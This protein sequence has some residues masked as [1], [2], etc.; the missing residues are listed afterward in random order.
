[1]ALIPTLRKRP[2]HLGR[3][4]MEKIRRVDRPTTRITADVPR[5]PQRANFFNRARFGDLGAKPA[6]EVSRFVAK[7]PLSAALSRL[8]AAQRLFHEG[9]VAPGQAPLPEDPQEVA[10]HIKALCYFLDADIVGICEVPAYAWYSHDLQGNP[11][12]ARHRYAIVML[13]DQGYETMAGSSGDDW[14]SGAQS[15]RAY[16]KGSMIACTVADYLRQLGF[17]ARAHTDADSQVLHL[18]LTLLAGLGELG[19]IGELVLNPFLG[20]RFKTSVVTTNLTLTVDK[21]IDFGLQDFCSSCMKCARECP[22]A[23]ISFGD[24][25]MFNGYEMW[26][27]DVEACVRY[28]VMNPG[29]SACGRCM[30]VCPF[31]K[32]GLFQYR[33]ALWVAIRIPPLRR[34][35]IWLDDALG[36]GECRP[37]W[38]WWLDLEKQDGRLGPAVKTNQRDLRPSRMPPPKPGI[39]LYPAESNPPPGLKG[40]YPV[41]RKA[42]RARSTQQDNG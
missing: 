11:I 4:P 28:R 20:P 21:P 38:K 25:I 6:A 26:K 15:M 24:K 22:C 2:L 8:N 41:D 1:M 5:V 35:L 34:A 16:L 39:A 12:E 14:I 18:P 13:I 23:A 17:D 30:K 10:N 19:R 29:G 33:L 42:A 36:F 31:N 32:Q 37:E 7:Y 9:E 40:P 3:Y 27:P